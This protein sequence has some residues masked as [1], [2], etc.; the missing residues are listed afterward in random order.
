MFATN[1]SST[2]SLKLVNN[3]N[4]THISNNVD[5]KKGIWC[6]VSFSLGREEFAQLILLIVHRNTKVL[7][8]SLLSVVA[9]QENKESLKLI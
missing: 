4:I 3:N 8:S 7:Q 1:L 2:N 6:I 5:K 9:L